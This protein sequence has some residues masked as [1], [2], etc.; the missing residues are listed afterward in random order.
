[1][2]EADYYTVGNINQKIGY[3][4]KTPNEE[5]PQDLDQYYAHLQIDNSFFDNGLSVYR[6]AQNKTWYDL[7]K[8][9]D[10][11]QWGMTSPTVNAYYTPSLNEIVFPAGIMQMPVFSGELPEYVS[12]GGFGATA[13]HELTH[14]FDDQGSKYDALG[15]YREWWDN[16]T[17]VKFESKTQCFIKQY[18]QFTVEG[19]EGEKVPVNGK[20]TLGENI[21]D[22]GGLNNAY[23]AWKKRDLTSPNPAVVGLEKFTNDQMFFIVYANSWCGKTKKE[24]LLQQ[25]YTDAHP[26]MDK[27]IIGPLDN[28]P[29]F[30]KA[31]NC[32]IRKDSNCH[33]W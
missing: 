24:A 28:S 21:A 12:Y 33:L 27:R 25:V 30:R 13:G 20:L 17:T 18:A 22:A 23:R 26:P 16:S 7:L 5:S 9:T 6:F 15:R 10:K 31:F 4:T 11:D 8:P 3:P 19:L 32:P 1:M 2:D 29:D 14:G